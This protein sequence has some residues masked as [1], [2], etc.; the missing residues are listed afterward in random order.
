MTALAKTFHFSQFQKNINDS[1]NVNFDD[2]VNYINNRNDGTLFWDQLRVTGSAVIGSAALATNATDGFLYVPTC[3]GV[4]SG[5]PTVFTG[6]AALI[7]D[8]TDNRLYFYSSGAWRN[9]GP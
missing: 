1:L 5:T 2:I 9:A 3:A 7:V 6:T 4:P 8:T